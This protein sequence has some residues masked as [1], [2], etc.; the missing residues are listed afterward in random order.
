GLTLNN[1]VF[2]YVGNN[3]PGAASVEALATLGVNSGS[4]FVNQTSG[5]GLNA[6]ATLTVGALTRNPGSTV[7][8]LPGGTASINNSFNTPFNRILV[9]TFG[10]GTTL[11]NGILPWA[12][13]GSLGGTPNQ[14]D[15]VTFTAVGPSNS[16]TPFTNYKTSLAAAGPTDTVRLTANETMTANKTV[17]AVLFAGTTANA[18][19]TITQNNFTLA[20]ASGALL[21]E[22][23]NTLTLNGGTVDFGAAEGI[24]GQNNANIAVNSTLTGTGGLTIY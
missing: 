23:N 6:S 19:I 4:S 21:A 8:F 16:V 2:N 10:A 13:V 18:S 1:G 14:F 11:S 12:T 24:L 3:T 20:V 22:G 9:N 5:S 7:S 15:F 17:N